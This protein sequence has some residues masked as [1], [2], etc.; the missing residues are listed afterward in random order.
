MFAT[1]CILKPQKF[2]TSFLQYESCSKRNASYFITLAHDI[3]GRCWGYGSIEWTFL[4]IFHFIAMWQNGSRTAVQQNGTWR[5]NAKVCHWIPSMNAIYELHLL[6]FTNA[7]WVCMEIKQWGSGWQISE[8]VRMT[9]GA[10]VYDRDMQVL[11]L[12]SIKGHSWWCWW[13]KNS[14]L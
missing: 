5:G 13:M 4:M 9:D 11:D 1:I 2:L 6:T 8:V 12:W 14:V 3:S 7:C 10:Q